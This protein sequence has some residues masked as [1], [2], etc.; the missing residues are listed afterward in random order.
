MQPN[1]EIA[2]NG[3]GLTTFC[4]GVQEWQN[5]IFFM[6]NIVADNTYANTFAEEGGEVSA[7]YFL[8]ER[9][10]PDAPIIRRIAGG[11]DGAD[12]RPSLHLFCRAT[13]QGG[14]AA[15]AAAAALGYVYF[16]R[17]RYVRHD[18]GARPI[19]FVFRL[20]DHAAG[21]RAPDMRA[22]LALAARPA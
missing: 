17:L 9:T 19:A 14:G 6:L 4:A 13:C 15:H 21:H 2:P 8:S 1:R 10:K 20:L 7:T 11:G 5:A 16:G 18:A 12:D 3:L 22:L